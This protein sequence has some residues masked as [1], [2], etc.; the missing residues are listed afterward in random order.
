MEERVTAEPKVITQRV[1]AKPK[2]ITERIIGQ[3]RVVTEQIIEPTRQRIVIQPSINK[4]IEQIRP[5]YNQGEDQLVTE[6]PV[7]MDTQYKTEQRTQVVN[8]PGDI[9]NNSYIVQ[10]SVKKIKTNVEILPAETVEKTLSPIEREAEVQNNV[11]TKTYNVAADQYIT[12]PYVQPIQ[13][14]ESV[15]IKW[16]QEEDQVIDNTP[17][18]KE[19]IYQQRH[20]TQ[21]VN[22]PGNVYYT[23]KVV[24]PTIN[25]EEVQVQFN[26]APTQETTLEPINEGTQYSQSKSVRRTVVP[27]T[28][29][30]EI[31]VG[32]PEPV[33]YDVPVY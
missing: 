23:Q 17:I 11:Q 13:Q 25:R 32:V 18:T 9:V 24:Q 33:V 1:T 20:R 19:A 26:Q 22:V 7:T 28:V 12:Q 27:Y 14:R 30:E 21:N 29:Q 15:D 3:P 16:D 4:T 6:G 8:V 2:I 31:P 5:Q 10:P